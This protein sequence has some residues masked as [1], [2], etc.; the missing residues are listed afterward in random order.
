MPMNAGPQ[1]EPTEPAQSAPPP[2]PKPLRMGQVV[3]IGLRILRR[4]WAVMLLLALLFAGPGALLTSATGMHFT[5]V[6]FDLFPEID[7]ATIGTNIDITQ[8]E[9]ERTLEALMPYLAATVLA[10]VLAS[11][12]ALAFSAVVADDYHA[13]TPDLGRVLRATLRRAPS[14]LVFMLLTSLI[15]IGLAIS[16][17]LAMSVATLAFSTTSIGAGGP[18]VF[19][20]LVV[21]VGLVVG[22]VYLTMRWAPAYPAMIEEDIGWRAALRRSWHLSGDNVWRIFV[23]SLFAAVLVAIVGSLLSQAAGLA[24]VSWLAPT[25]GLDE[26]V[27]QVI[28]LAL[29]TL[30]VAPLPPVLT[31]VLFFDL[32][33]RRD[34]PTPEPAP[35]TP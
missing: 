21:G 15:I 2:G 33:A 26:R 24:L 30:L 28:A 5:E 27:A 17:L 12:G 19:L 9:L 32:R 18:G 31:A 3:E 35:P 8:A 6:A 11:I 34:V 16:G 4:H 13:R 7:E 29:G 10:G 25:L 22:V 20:A 1:W 23:I 14:A